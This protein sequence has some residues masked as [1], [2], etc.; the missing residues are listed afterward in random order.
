[1]ITWIFVFF[2]VCVF[3]G[4]IGCLECLKM[5]TLGTLGMSFL[6]LLISKYVA[7]Q[8]ISVWLAP[9]DGS[10]PMSH[11]SRY[12]CRHESDKYQRELLKFPSIIFEKSKGYGKKPG[13]IFPWKQQS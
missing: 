10:Q 12:A 6:Q 2:C 4:V 1:M 5:S 8:N 7:M 3:F 11:K 13:K 9:Q